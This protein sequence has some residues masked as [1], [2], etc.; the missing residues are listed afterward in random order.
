[1]LKDCDYTGKDVEVDGNLITANG[2][3]SA[4]S[5]SLALCEKLGATPKF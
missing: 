3:K 1:M 5:F 2:P 4:M